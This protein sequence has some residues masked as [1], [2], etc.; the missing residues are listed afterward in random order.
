MNNFI[1]MENLVK[2]N[3]AM[4][5]HLNHKNNILMMVFF[6]LTNFLYLHYIIQNLIYIFI[7]FHHYLVQYSIFDNY[8]HILVQK[9]SLNYYQHQLFHNNLNNQHQIDNGNYFLTQLYI[10]NLHYYFYYPHRVYIIYLHLLTKL[11]NFC[12]YPKVWCA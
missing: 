11:M 7:L 6:N 3:Y 12:I 1:K 5:N 9:Q 2:V 4:N 8:R 10:I